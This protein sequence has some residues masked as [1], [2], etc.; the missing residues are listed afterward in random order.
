MLVCAYLVHKV[1]SMQL[2]ICSCDIVLA[3][4]FGVYRADSTLQTG[5]FDERRVFSCCTG[6]IIAR[7]PPFL[8]VEIEA[9][10]FVFC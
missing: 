10:D 4:I 5:R 1:V 6:E 9:I 7:K 2:Y 8:Q 3:L